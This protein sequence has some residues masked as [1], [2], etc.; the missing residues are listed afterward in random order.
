LPLQEDLSLLRASDSQIS[1]FERIPI[2]I[3]V[4]VA[5]VEDNSLAIDQNYNIKIPEALFG[6]KYKEDSFEADLMYWHIFD[7]GKINSIDVDRKNIKVSTSFSSD[8]IMLD[9]NYTCLIEDVSSKKI[10][11]ST[12]IDVVNFIGNDN[13]ISLILRKEVISNLNIE[14]N[15]DKFTIHIAKI[16][17]IHITKNKYISSTGFITLKLDNIISF[18]NLS[19]FINCHGYFYYEVLDFRFIQLKKNDVIP[20]FL[21]PNKYNTLGNALDDHFKN[22]DVGASCFSIPKETNDNLS[23]VLERL[24]EL[25]NSYGYFLVPLFDTRDMKD[26]V[27]KYTKSA[28]LEE[29]YLMNFIVK[30]MNKVKVLASFEYKFVPKG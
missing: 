27:L 9:K 29:T 15:P 5:L 14:S 30:K 21:L 22:S 17:S 6:T 19:P 4:A 28:E 12:E 18:S 10:I 16:K 13:L 3:G 26:V 7:S 20:D 8:L 2:F 25:G 1:L 23:L 24:L 11:F